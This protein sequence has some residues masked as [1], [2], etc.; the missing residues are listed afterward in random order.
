MKLRPHHL[1]DI[2]TKS[3]HGLEFEPHPYGHALHTVAVQVLT[4]LDQ[5]VEFVLAAD[6][7]CQPCRHLRPDGRCEDVLHQLEEPVSKQAYN[8]ALD[9]RLFAYLKIEPGTRMTVGAFLELLNTHTPGVEKIC[10]HPGE[11]E[12]ERLS[13]LQEGL[14]GLGVREKKS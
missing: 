7:I 6:A 8:D 13:G 14:I 3:V 5:E 10:A 11:K 1:I 4:H 2:I 12:E 9:K